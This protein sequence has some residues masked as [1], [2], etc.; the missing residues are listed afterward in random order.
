LGS[1]L[2]PTIDLILANLSPG[3]EYFIID[4]GSTDS[5][6][7][8]IHGYGGSLTGWVGELDK[9]YADTLAKGFAAIEVEK[10]EPQP[11][12]VKKAA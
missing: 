1:Y 7:D 8:L 10:A 12:P 9:D 5:S 3:D 11:T 6:V 2:S 4:G